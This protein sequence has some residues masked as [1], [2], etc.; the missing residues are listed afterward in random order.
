[1]LDFGKLT[2]L[3]I[4]FSARRNEQGQLEPDAEEDVV[5]K[6]LGFDAYENAPK[7]EVRNAASST[8]ASASNPTL[9]EN[10]QKS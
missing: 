10:D 5:Q 4:L 6:S 2:K 9:G 8:P 7:V 3:L 1:M